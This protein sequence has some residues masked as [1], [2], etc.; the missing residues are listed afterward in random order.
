MDNLLTG[1]KDNVKDME[2]HP[3]F[4]FI[5]ADVTRPFNVQVETIVHL[6]SPASPVD[7]LKLAV[8]TMLANS[9]GTYHALE[10][11]RNARARFILASTSEVY[12]D[13]LVNPQSEDYYGNVNP[14]G[15]RSCYDESKR[16]A[17]AL[18]YTYNQKH[19]VNTT[20]LRIFNTYGPAMRKEDGRV[21]PNFINQALAGE[22]LTIYGDGTQTRCF[23]YIDDLVEAIK[24]VIYKPELNGYVINL[25]SDQEMTVL[26]LAHL[27]KKLV[28][29]DSELV[30]CEL[31]KDDPMQRRPDITLAKK[32]LGWEPRTSLEEGLKK[33]IEWF[34][35]ENRSRQEEAT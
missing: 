21:T 14:V 28:G 6:A 30:F 17:E 7:Y 13:P 27:I 32:V 31:P 20:I 9:L 10:L 22:P 5:L 11:A 35:D 4:Q 2:R 8:E 26:E 23:C 34:K 12:G 3:R 29:S 24:K 25:G 15:P 18:T 19:G 1:K 16:F 33:L